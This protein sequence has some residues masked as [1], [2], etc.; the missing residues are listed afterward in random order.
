MYSITILFLCLNA[1]AQ[2]G[3]DIIGNKITYPLQSP[4][5]DSN[6]LILEFSRGVCKGFVIRAQA[7]QESVIQKIEIKRVS[8]NSKK[9][10]IAIHG[11]VSYDFYYRSRIDTPFAQSNFQQHTE[12]VY[13]N[14]LLKEQ[15]PFKIGFASRQSNS[16]FFRDFN[17]MNFQFDHFAYNKKIKQ[18]LVNQLQLKQQK[19][20]SLADLDSILKKE[21][22]KL[23]LLKLSV[24]NP[25]TLQKIIE[26]REDEFRKKNE[27]QI[28]EKVNYSTFP[29]EEELNFTYLNNKRNRIFYIKSKI[30]SLEEKFEDVTRKKEEEIDSISKKVAII[31]QKIDSLKTVSQSK[32]S[33]VRQKIY[34]AG[35]QKELLK[36]AADNGLEPDGNPKL[37][38][39]LS[40]VKN[41]S[42][43]RNEVNYTELTVQNIT[44][45]G[46]NVEYNTSIYAAFAAGKVDYRFRDFFNK[47]SFK[48]DQYLVLGRVGIGNKDKHTIILS[49]FNGRKSL[50]QYGQSNPVG[51]SI[52]IVGYSLETIMK[53]NENTY[54]SLEFAK[55]TRPV[56]GDLNN[57][58]EINSLVQ[59]KDRTN[60]GLNIKAQTIIPKTN[61]RLSGFFR[62]TGENFQSFSL[63]SYNTDQT[64]WLWRADQDIF[65]RK[66]GI[67]AMLRRNDFTNPF[68]EKTFK[69]ST[70]FS[71][72][73]LKLRIPKYPTLSIGYYPG[74]QFY[75]IDNDHIRENA[76]Y[77]LNGTVNYGY[78]FKG[79]NMNSTFLYNRYM[80]KAN[81][82]GF[83]YYKGINIYASQTIFI[84]KLQLQGAY[85]VTKQPE[86]QYFSLESAADYTITK[87]LRLSASLK[88]NKVIGGENYWG[89]RIL[90]NMEIKK[91]GRFQLQHEKSFL[92]T[93]H[94]Q[95][96]PVEIGRVSWYKYF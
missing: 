5:L 60:T 79:Y 70:T 76:Y 20:S 7:I 58:K 38:K 74:T 14:I 71:S 65:K 22:K 54:L 73:L 33:S 15:F 81:D 12:R 85:S 6:N 25:A 84:K 41:F 52:N 24:N 36:I 75:L 86:L 42:I 26:Q 87:L 31:Q 92:P 68:T 95:L 18:Q 13:L 50:S 94:G 45:T 63:F 89:E 10:F 39:F 29:D 77:I 64:S 32:F 56:T 40:G 67:T 17:D 37:N 35:N 69:T 90:I 48:N 43:G 34:N 55:S 82:S 66:I 4:I 30:D 27:Q 16:G 49:L 23:E 91:L 2:R 96:Y 8:A 19:L 1:C 57:N 3:K 78:F 93:I 21:L 51:N 72:L 46:V 59:F 83:V 88:Y 11:E 80:N 9:R 44:I 47:K 28:S 61:T 62:R 53:K